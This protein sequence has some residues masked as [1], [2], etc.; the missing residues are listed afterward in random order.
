M[1]KI[2][3]YVIFVILFSCENAQI[4]NPRVTNK[5]IDYESWLKSHAGNTGMNIA[6]KWEN[7]DW[8]DT[9]LQQDGNFVKGKFGNYI[10]HGRI[11]GKTVYF[12]FISEGIPY[13]FAKLTLGQDTKQVV[14]IG[15]Y[16]RS[17]D[18]KVGWP[19]MMSK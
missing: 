3:L 15:Q 1:K 18:L 4:R 16:S 5:K 10:A 14:L 13:Y 12:A 7:P 11:N 6:G 9:Y 19:I 8:G 2:L 17:L